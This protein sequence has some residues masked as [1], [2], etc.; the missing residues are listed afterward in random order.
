VNYYQ[1]FEG[2][3]TIL[4]RNLLYSFYNEYDAAYLPLLIEPQANSSLS[5]SSCFCNV[6]LFLFFRNSLNLSSRFSFGKI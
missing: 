5:F 2:E 1:P 6:F 4:K 3:Y